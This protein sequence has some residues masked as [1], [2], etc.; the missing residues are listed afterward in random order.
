MTNPA[1]LQVTERRRRHAVLVR[2]DTA[3]LREHWARFA[4][5][6]PC[7]PLRAAQTGMVMLRGRIQGDGAPFNFGEATVSRATVRA[8]AGQVGVGVVLG[9]DREK[10]ELVARFDAASQMP[11]LADEIERE[12]IGPLA[13][14]QQQARANL[15]AQTAASRVEFFTLVRGET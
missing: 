6:V 15:L 1:D 3:A 12:V 5:R 7:A 13:Y 4:A 8:Q 11:H 10:A 2:A 14:A 9:R